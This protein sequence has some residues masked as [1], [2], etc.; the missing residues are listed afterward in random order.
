[1][2]STVP[3]ASI[4]S[5]NFFALP[6]FPVYLRLTVIAIASPPSR[7][8]QPIVSTLQLPQHPRR[9]AAADGIAWEALCDDSPCCNDDVVADR[10]AW[11]NR[12]IAVNPAVLAYRDRTGRRDQIPRPIRPRP[13]TLRRI[14]IVLAAVD[15]HIGSDEGAV[16]YRYEIRI[17]ECAV[18]VHEDIVAEADVHAVRTAER[19]HKDSTCSH[20][21]QELLCNL[22]LLFRIVRSVELAQALRLAAAR[23]RHDPDDMT[24]TRRP[25]RAFRWS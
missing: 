13:E 14:H 2:A 20:I 5:A 25:G 12:R 18:H 1:M 21:S 15:L 3:D 23:N 9:H 6:S 24:R 19:S 8:A 10:H 22:A 4:S 17:E 7:L 11:K 16:P